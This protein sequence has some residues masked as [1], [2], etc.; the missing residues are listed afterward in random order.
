V[1]LDNAVDTGAVA[2]EAFPIWPSRRAADGDRLDRAESSAGAGGLSLFGALT[3]V[4]GRP[5]GS[6]SMSANLIKA[7][8]RRMYFVPEGQYDRSLARSA[9]ESAPQGEPSRRV[10]CDSLELCAPI[11]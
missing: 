6:T 11:R 9:W 8:A 5:G 7:S 2:P 3:L 1:A 4:Q 10:R